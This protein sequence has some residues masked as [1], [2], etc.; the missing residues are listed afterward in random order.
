MRLKGWKRPETV[1]KCLAAVRLI[2]T[3]GCSALPVPPLA[4]G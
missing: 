2:Y 4:L 3:K 1:L